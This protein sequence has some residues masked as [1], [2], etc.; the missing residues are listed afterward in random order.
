MPVSC[1]LSPMCSQG[2][3]KDYCEM[4]RVVVDSNDN[5]SNVFNYHGEEQ[6]RWKMVIASV[7]WE[8]DLFVLGLAFVIDNDF[9]SCSVMYWFYLSYDESL[10]KPPR[11]PAK[12]DEG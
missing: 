9:Q 3:S 10:L 5:K 1:R 2:L 6:L 4:R 7:G 11:A 12:P 8:R